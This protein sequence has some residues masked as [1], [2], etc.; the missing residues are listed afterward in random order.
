MVLYLA[1]WSFD[2]N[3]AIRG[4][5]GRP[6]TNDYGINVLVLCR[7]SSDALRCLSY[8]FY[9]T[10][11]REDSSLSFGDGEIKLSR[12]KIDSRGFVAQ[13]LMMDGMK[14]PLFLSDMKSNILRFDKIF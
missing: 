1:S 12:R 7:N 4:R 8:E 9:S 2:K 11:Y 14:E 13:Y 6:K 3:T 10:I 5:V